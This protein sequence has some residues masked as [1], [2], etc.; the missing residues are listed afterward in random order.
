MYCIIIISHLCFCIC[1]VT[2]HNSARERHLEISAKSALNA[3]ETQVVDNCFFS[4][5]SEVVKATSES[6]NGTSIKAQVSVKGPTQP[7]SRQ[8]EI[9]M[10]SLKPLLQKN[11]NSFCMSV[12]DG[13]CSMD[14]FY[15]PK[16]PSGRNGHFI[17]SAMYKYPWYFLQMPDTSTIMEFK[18]RAKAMC[19]MSYE[20]VSAYSTNLDTSVK[21]DTI[22]QYNCFLSSYISVLLERKW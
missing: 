21:K 4:G 8:F 12:Y 15:Q 9:C 11:L 10:E 2:G 17:A 5:Y 1:N 22:L 7:H 3:K 19:A 18:K 16:L 14:G 13:E 6:Q 20:D